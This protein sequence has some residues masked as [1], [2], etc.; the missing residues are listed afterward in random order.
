MDVRTALKSLRSNQHAQLGKLQTKS[1]AEVELLENLTSYLKK[2]AD[3]E[4]SYSQSLE[5]LAKSFSNKKF[6]KAGVLS[7][8]SSAA[9]SLDDVSNPV[10]QHTR[11]THQVFSTIVSETEQLARSKASAATQL[12]TGMADVVKEF[13][14]E[15]VLSG[16]RNADFAS[17]YMQELWSAY[18]DLDRAKHQYDK[19]AKEADSSKRKYEEAVRKPRQGLLGLV[20]P[21][22]SE[23]RVEKL[24]AKWKGSARKIVDQRN[25][26]LLSLESANALQGQYYER[27]LPALLQKADES[28]YRLFG[29]VMTTYADAEKSFAESRTR[30]A[31]TISAVVGRI[32]R[33]MDEG[34]FLQENERIFQRPDA[35]S[36]DRSPVDDVNIL[37][38]DDVTRVTLGK[39]LATLLARDEDIS[40]N[41]VKRE[42]E[43]A[44]LQHLTDAYTAQPSF[45]SALTASEQRLE[46]HNAI[47]LFQAMKTRIGAQIAMLTNAGVLPVVAVQPSTAVQSTAAQT[48]AVALYDYVGKEQGEA[49]I[50]EGDSLTVLEE[51]HDGWVK[52]R[53]QPSQLEGLVPAEYIQISVARSSTSTIPTTING[54]AGSSRQVRA[55]YVTLI[56]LS[57]YKAQDEPELSFIAG[58]TI[59]VLDI[60]DDAAEDAWWGGRCLRTGQTGAF[61]VSFTE[62]W[63]AAAAA[64]GAK[65]SRSFSSLARPSVGSMSSAGSLAQISGTP[66]LGNGGTSSS[67]SLEKARVLYPYDATCEGELSLRVGDVITIITK[68]T[69]SDA[70]WEGEGPSGRGQFPVNFVEP[71]LTTDGQGPSAPTPSISSLPR[72]TKQ[73]KALYDYAAASDDELTFRTG[74][75]IRLIDSSDPDWWE[76]ELDGKRGAMPANYLLLL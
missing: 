21:L 13:Q 38:I 61:P 48:T 63:Q 36:Y 40:P 42:R 41:L 15:K 57:D 47:D 2:R 9:S 52:I 46:I 29:S 39:R 17:K 55:I 71:I 33:K 64:F 68:K 12:V 27:D 76:G 70:W 54:Q 45:G 16:K 19:T 73:V 5:K 59:E 7:P 43:L 56:M 60:N 34:I 35:F 31:E 25:D 44:G 51:E 65:S 14:K 26:Y 24:H 22:N 49:S 67:S 8:S 72:P 66:G 75:H 6:K 20:S 4:A 37:I 10:D 74:D 23:D 18:D 11:I 58:D 69:G 28:Y 30:S 3:I 62:G 50:K 53:H 1:D 32:D